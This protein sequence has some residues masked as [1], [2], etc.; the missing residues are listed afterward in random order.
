MVACRAMDRTIRTQLVE[1]SDI[2]RSEMERETGF[3]A[4]GTKHRVEF[5]YR[6]A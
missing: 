6:L 2:E 4:P 5:S 3:V 1:M